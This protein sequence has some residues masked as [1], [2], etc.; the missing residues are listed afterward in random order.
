MSSHNS[1]VHIVTARVRIHQQDG[2]QIS[3]ENKLVRST[4]ATKRSR[5]GI[6]N[7]E[8]FDIDN[9]VM[10]NMILG[11]AVYDRQHKT[12]VSDM[13]LLITGVAEITCT[14]RQMRAMQQGRYRIA[15]VL[16]KIDQI[17]PTANPPENT[18]CVWRVFWNFNPAGAHY[19]N[20]ASL[21][22]LESTETHFVQT[23]TFNFNP[24]QE[25]LID[26][27]DAGKTVS[28]RFDNT[29]SNAR[30]AGATASA[31][32]VT[33]I[34][35]GLAGIMLWP[36]TK[37]A[38]TAKSEQYK[39][40]AVMC[41]GVATL[42][43][44]DEDLEDM[45]QHILT[46]IYHFYPGTAN[47]DDPG[48]AA[49]DLLFSSGFLGQ[50]LEVYQSSVRIRIIAH[51]AKEYPWQDYQN[52]MRRTGLTVISSLPATTVARAS[53]VLPSVR[54]ALTALNGA[55]RAAAS[56]AGSAAATTAY[57]GNSIARAFFG[58]VLSVGRRIAGVVTPAAAGRR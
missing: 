43:M 24:E 28:G 42:Y 12:G 29:I 36:L 8:V 23:R 16:R 5:P 6:A 7:V 3:T 40:A 18:L 15:K 14:V 9:D 55:A 54:E 56:A 47:L 17:G 41:R 27:F 45:R 32:E 31:F 26:S 11:L 46:G 51:A 57:Y 13:A 49:R 48:P 58:N 25:N 33:D 50:V 39:K 37:K 2:Q 10:N 1:P 44:Q 35:Q 52:A 22:G 21:A 34:T 20:V 53:G 4:A 30:T 19:G 38:I